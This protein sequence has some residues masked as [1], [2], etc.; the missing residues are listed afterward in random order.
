MS[1][2]LPARR[3]SE[4]PAE[5][6]AAA[7]VPDPRLIESF[8]QVQAQDLEVRKQ[9][10]EIRREELDLRRQES[11]QGFTFAQESLKVQ[12]ED[13]KEIRKQQK[14][15]SWQGLVIVLSILLV[16]A[17]VLVYAINLNKDQFVLELA[18]VILTALGGGGVGYV[19]GHRKAS[20]SEGVSDSE[21]E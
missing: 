20:K 1:S 6:R 14:R 15:E 5:Q 13:L 3:E 21:S 2:E 10:I 7:T 18:R 19:I 16:V 9:E 4:N 17:G 8:L 12:A 11:T